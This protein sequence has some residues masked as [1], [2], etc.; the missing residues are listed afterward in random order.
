VHRDWVELAEPS[1]TV[2]AFDPRSVR[3]L[4]EPARRWLTRAIA[5]GTPL[6]RRVELTQHGRIRIG[7]W[8]DFRAHQVIAAL[9]GYVWACTTRV[10]GVPV[11]GYDRLAHGRGD[12]VHR[13]FG[14][15]A[16]VDESGPDLTRS[17]AGRLVSEVVWTPA[18]L[19]A[20]DV[21]WEPVDDRSAI[22]RLPHG[23][24]THEVTVTVGPTG[25]LQ[26]VTLL[27]WARADRGPYQLRPFGAEVHRE[28]TFDGFTVPI[29]VTA[30]YDHDSPRWPGCAFIRISVDDAVHR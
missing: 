13:A 17:A 19:L 25:A 7:A 30:G 15:V 23:G 18:A 11:H 12:M 6:R 27:R 10:A 8:R 28:G 4:P 24:E 2:S 22:V 3:D 20:P 29:E 21:V 16:L 9:D 26:R 5:P 1:G 14:R